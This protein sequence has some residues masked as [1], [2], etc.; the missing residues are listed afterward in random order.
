MSDLGRSEN[1][2]VSAEEDED[3]EEGKEVE[4]DEDVEEDCYWY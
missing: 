1:V 3:V 2:E 4:E